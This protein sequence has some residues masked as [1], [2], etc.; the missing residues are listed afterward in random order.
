[1]VILYIYTHIC[2]YGIDLECSG[3][4]ITMKLNI[5]LLASENISYAQE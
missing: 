2:I 5:P 4:K 1:M 3:I